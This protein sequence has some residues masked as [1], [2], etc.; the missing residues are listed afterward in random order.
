MKLT[1]NRRDKHERTYTLWAGEPYDS[2]AIRLY[3]SW[4]GYHLQMLHF[5]V[6]GEDRDV[7]VTLGL[8]WLFLTLSLRSVFPR[9]WRHRSYVWAKRRAEMLSVGRRKMYAYELDPLAG[10]CTG[11]SLHD[12]SWWFRLWNDEG[13]WCRED[14]KNWPWNGHGW[15]YTFHWFDLLFGKDRYH[16]EPGSWHSA[17]ATINGVEYPMR[18][19]L[20]RVRWSRRWPWAGRWWSRYTISIAGHDRD[21]PL[22]QEGVSPPMYAGKGENSWDLDDDCIYSSTGPI[23]REPWTVGD[24]VAAYVASYEQSVKRYGRASA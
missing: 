10:R 6:G 12:G 7:G 8:R 20:C 3:A 23:R 15:A 21:D 1:I 24:A 17:T 19:H 22:T 13:G 2:P 18:V 14:A 9:D 4:G 16:K 11:V 5:D